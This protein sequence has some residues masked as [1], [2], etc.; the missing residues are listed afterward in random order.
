MAKFTMFNFRY[1]ELSKHMNKKATKVG[2]EY[3]AVGVG[4]N[5]DPEELHVVAG[6]DKQH[7]F[8][9]DS[10]DDVKNLV[11]EIAIQICQGKCIRLCE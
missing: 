6:A 8:Q 7:I 2:V 5:V 3:I 10:F 9:V 11:P 4:T 1:L